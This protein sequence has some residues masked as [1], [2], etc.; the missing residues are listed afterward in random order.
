MLPPSQKCS[1]STKSECK[2]VNTDECMEYSK[3]QPASVNVEN[4][5]CKIHITKYKIQ[6]FTNECMEYSK[7][8]RAS[9]LKTD[10]AFKRP[11]AQSAQLCSAP[12]YPLLP[13]LIQFQP[14]TC[15]CYFRTKCTVPC[16]NFSCPGSSIPTFDIGPTWTQRVTLET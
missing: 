3:L 10:K 4:R 15:V 16:V 5:K 9:S 11:S 12:K 6:K 13:Y 8:R 1:P 7:L 2:M 14:N